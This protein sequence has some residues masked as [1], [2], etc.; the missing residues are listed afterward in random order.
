MSTESH[1]LP[2]RLCTALLLLC[3]ALINTTLSAQESDAP[4]SAEVIYSRTEV[5]TNRN[6]FVTEVRE[7]KV[8][9]NR[10]GRRY[11][12][13]QI[14]V[15]GFSKLNSARV[16]VC[17]ADG[18]EIVKHSKGDLKKHCGFDAVS[19][20]SD[21]C[22]FT[23]DVSLE[24][25]PYTVD[26]EYKMTTKSL[27]F[28]KGKR[29]QKNIPVRYSSYSLNADASGS[30]HVKVYG[31][32]IEPTT[33][34]INGRPYTKWEVRDL[35]KYDPEA[36]VPNEQNSVVSISV[37]M[38]NLRLD[39]YE[40]EYSDWNGIARFY[41][42]LAED[43]YL[44]PES[45]PMIGQA[46]DEIV[47]AAYDEVRTQTRYV[48]I[49]IDIGGWQ[50]RPAEWTQQNRYGDCKDMSTLLVSLL[51]NRGVEAY[52]CLISTRSHGAIDTTF[53]S[54][55]F[56]HL[57]AAAINGAD[58]VYLDPTC[59]M[60]PYG[61]VPIGDQNVPLLLIT[62]AGG[63]ICVVPQPPMEQNS[64]RRT[65]QLH[66]EA[67]NR[68]TATTTAVCD[69]F[70]AYFIR[71]RLQGASQEETDLFVQGLFVDG[72]KRYVLREYQINNLD[73]IYLP[74]ELTISATSR[75]PIREIRGTKYVKPFVFSRLGRYERLD[76]E[77]R[78]DPVDLYC[79]EL[80][81]DIVTISWDST[82]PEQPVE[83][84]LD[85]TMTCDLGV[86]SLKSERST[87]T[88][89]LELR[90]GYNTDI[91]PPEQFGQ[92]VAFRDLYRELLNNRV[93]F[94]VSAEE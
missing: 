84:P 28:L 33:E 67:D 22:F 50:P 79:P 68:V 89:R 83:L 87:D 27:F 15:D 3:L 1:R 44:K 72:K 81:H 56:N 80:E 7:R 36:Y 70:Y 71:N 60:C 11:G 69:G 30:Y 18:N 13:V 55:R 32:E 42:S 63:K 46:F 66:V 75:R 64:V 88:V 48:A 20:A 9:N 21:V 78:D 29:F 77:D 43:Q 86:L 65:T 91:V 37:V 92:F 54:F 76:L 85:T 53:P 62:D 31:T 35:P 39:D 61:T 41:A 10:A 24:S 58:T 4:P 12:D 2:E 14:S 16:V 51:R 34:M 59:D 6:S 57:I 82:L 45:E 25:Y 5:Q 94:S 73:D 17:D 38:D 8:I 40:F 93:K 74:V 19:V 49:S 47:R 90:R 26:V 52:P 23:D